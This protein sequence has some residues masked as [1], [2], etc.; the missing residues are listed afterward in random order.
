MDK[1]VHGERTIPMPLPLLVS[2]EEEKA[3]QV[4]LFPGRRHG[5]FAFR[6]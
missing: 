6:Q 5:P 2:S 4:I 3:W 1:Q